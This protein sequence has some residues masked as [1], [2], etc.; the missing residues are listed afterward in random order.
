MR[1]RITPEQI[2]PMAVFDA[3]GKSKLVANAAEL[4]A[5]EGDWRESPAAFEKHPGH[6]A[7]L[8]QNAPDP[9]QVA[10]E[11]ENDRLRKEL[12]TFKGKK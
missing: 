7:Y 1:S 5:L 9:E 8:E 6:A 12:E 11:A 4:K 2:Y 10:L 3:A